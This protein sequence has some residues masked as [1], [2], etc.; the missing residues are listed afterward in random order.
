[1]HTICRSQQA[2]KFRLGKALQNYRRRS[3]GLLYLHEDSHLRI[4]Y[5]DL[6]ASNILLDDELHPKISDFEMARLFVVDQTQGSTS[7]IMGT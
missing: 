4:V 5:R 2:C 1:M 6:K 7:R 3:R